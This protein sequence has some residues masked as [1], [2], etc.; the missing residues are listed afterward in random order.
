MEK[1]SSDRNSEAAEA[2][3]CRGDEGEAEGQEALHLGMKGIAP[4]N[5]G[6]APGKKGGNTAEN[7]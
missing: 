2:G 1:P 6:N 5:R 3:V 7:I 4:R